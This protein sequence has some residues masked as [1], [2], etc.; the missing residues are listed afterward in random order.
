MELQERVLSIL[1]R[2]TQPLKTGEIAT[3]AGI[4]KKDV[5]KALHLLSREDKVYSPSRCSWQAK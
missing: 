3:I 5:E 2:A 4:E 1:Q